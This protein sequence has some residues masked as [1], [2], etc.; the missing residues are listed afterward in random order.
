MVFYSEFCGCSESVN[1]HIYSFLGVIGVFQIG[2][3][4]HL[5]SWIS[6]VGKLRITENNTF[7]NF[8]E[9]INYLEAEITLSQLF[10][11]LP[12][13]FSPAENP[14][15]DIVRFIVNM[16]ACVNNLSKIYKK[17]ISLIFRL[18]TPSLDWHIKTAYHQYLQTK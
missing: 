2:K 16:L 12:G 13:H 6:R 18:S 10:H 17:S 4:N 8:Q 15:C 14:M 9:N 1:K 11:A 5:I 7:H 3:K